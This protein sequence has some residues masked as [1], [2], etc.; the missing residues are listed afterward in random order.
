M[1][2]E[3]FVWAL[4]LKPDGHN[5]RTAFN[6]YMPRIKESYKNVTLA[7]YMETKNLSQLKTTKIKHNLIFLEIA[8]KQLFYCATIL[9]YFWLKIAKSNT[10]CSFSFARAKNLVGLISTYSD[11]IWIKLS[12]W[13]V[14]NTKTNLALG[15]TLEL[16]VIK[17]NLFAIKVE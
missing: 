13:R 1:V 2:K 17:S 3:S 16:A 12:P 9:T 15:N 4:R 14:A 10:I 11:P 6:L 7:L 5:I 8:H